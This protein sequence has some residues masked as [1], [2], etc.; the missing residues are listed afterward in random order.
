MASGTIDPDDSADVRPATPSVSASSTLRHRVAGFAAPIAGLSLVQ[1]AT[2]FIPLLLL[3]GAMYALS[4]ITVWLA[5]ALAPVAAGFVVRIFIIQ[6]DCGH[7]AFFRSR[8]ANEIMGNLCALVTLAPFALWRR[9][10]AGHHRI[11]NN[12]DQ[13]Q[14][15]ADIYSSCR[16]VAE[17]RAMSWSARLGFR[18]LHHPVIYLLLLPPLVFLV[19]YR[20][21]FDTPRDWLRERRG[22][23]LTT[24][25]VVAIF[26]ALCLLFGWRHALLVQLS[27]SI[28]AS[29][30]GVWLFSLQHRFE[31]VWWARQDHWN[32]VSASLF[33]SSY[34]RL[35]RLLQWFTGNIGFH[36]I[37]HLNSRI[38]N[39]RL[40]ACFE[41]VPD[42]R[43]V[44]TLSLRDGLRA[45]R[46]ILWDEQQGRMIRL[47]DLR[48]PA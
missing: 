15:G 18:I 38:P 31:Q 33:G 32:A 14:S 42:L 40:Q 10:H 27:V 29:I 43:T 3:L 35:P 19:L 5:L 34:L 11:W 1:I 36:H 24:L 21:P 41:A 46:F 30:Y 8:R 37:H 17:Y 2:S 23:N 4:E 45:F 47:A 16:T 39:Y 12:L 7:G 6:H 44:P 26:A 25:G 13:R 9:Q 22:M 20:T 48:Q 28:I